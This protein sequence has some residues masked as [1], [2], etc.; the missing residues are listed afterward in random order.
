MI[1]RLW[2]LFIYR[3]FIN[4][5][6][7]VGDVIFVIT[8]HYPTEPWS[9]D[10][11][12]GSSAV[13]IDI[14]QRVER[15]VSNLHHFFSNIL[16]VWLL[17]RC[18]SFPPHQLPNS[19]ISIVL[20]WYRVCYR[21]WYRVLVYGFGIGFWYRALYRQVCM[22]LRVG[23]LGV[24]KTTTPT[25]GPI[26]AAMFSLNAYYFPFWFILYTLTPSCPCFELVELW[27]CR[28]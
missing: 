8:L 13:A 21:V 25:P 14:I 5:I 9:S 18:R 20:L 2:S 19:S 26:S 16:F 23:K 4:I 15:L 7:L 24:V 6:N 22:T 12:Y 27:T 1:I 11:V 28:R 10:L 3:I 17:R